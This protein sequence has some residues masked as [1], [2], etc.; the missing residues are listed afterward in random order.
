MEYVLERPLDGLDLNLLLTLRALLRHSS[1]SEAAQA[2]GS[3]PPTVSRGLA[4]LRLAFGDP[5][6]VRTGRGM[7]RTPVAETMMEPLDRAL[8]HI[9]RLRGAA[10]FDPAT[11]GRTFRVILPD[12]VS[13][14]VLSQLLAD[15]AEAPLTS[16]EVTGFEGDDE[17]MLLS[18]LADVVVGAARLQHPD[19][20]T[21]R[22]EGEPGWS[23]LLGPAHPAYGMK[24]LTRARWLG[25]RH[26]QLVPGRAGSR[27][28]NVERHLDRLGLTRRVMA[29]V[30]HLLGLAELVASSDLV[31]TLPTPSARALT[32]L[33]PLR[34]LP[35]PLADLPRLAVRLTWHAT[36]H[37]DAGHRWFRERLSARVGAFLRS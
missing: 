16:L 9:E 7:A 15:L 14:G 26:A 22:L 23:V 24:R 34:T 21:S 5:L 18:G 10:G 17:A 4:Q 13:V 12:V 30:G 31:A 3:T 37:Q 33:G 2:L 29:R 20:Y 25:S 6:L 11:D 19:F 8:G 1:V 36:Q 35:H 28:G 27:R 32:R